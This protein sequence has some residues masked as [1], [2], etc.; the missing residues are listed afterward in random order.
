M[1]VLTIA[2]RNL[3]RNPRRTLLTAG[4]IGFAE[5]ILV[6]AH[7]MQSG[8]FSV[9]VDNISRISTGHIQIQVP[10]YLDN[11]RLRSTVHGAER[12]R[13]RV[14]DI[15]GVQV[16]ALRAAS[17]AL[18][19]SAEERTYGAMI[20]GVEPG[21]ERVASTLPEMV[22]VGRY[23]EEGSECVI[24]AALG[25]NL[26]V[27]VGDELVVLGNAKDGG[28]AALVLNVV[29]IVETLQPELDR[30]IVH[31]PITAF[32]EGFG[33]G[34]EA[35]A[36]VITADDVGMVGAVA[37]R[38][39]AVV[40][41]SGLRV[42]PWNELL[43]GVEQAIEVKRVGADFMFVLLAAL[44][45]FAV[46]N[47]FIMVVF[48]RS[49]EF[50]MLLALGNQPRR[51][52]AM[53]QLEAGALAFVGVA[54]GGIVAAALV[55]WLERVG[56]PLPAQDAADLLAKFQL[57]SRIHPTLTWTPMIVGA[58]VMFLATQIA[59]LVPALKVLRLEPTQALR[60]ES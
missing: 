34:D 16:A 32:R 28:V 58:V 38:V 17:F 42:L 54:V 12:L 48:E 9:M 35:N 4:G 24:G 51:I 26:G 20:T 56:I 59:A 39:S 31:I 14:E 1:I 49:Q 53:L 30:A 10:G 11:P 47:T 33:L 36:V 6:F 19:S 23:I 25:R 15:P 3:W 37:A 18:V 8:S 5:L 46:I 13:E 21:R 52:V 2:L 41:G 45:S 22:R 44:V 43:A 55:L 29:G 60:Q 40:E 57:P 27:G 50:G 7:S